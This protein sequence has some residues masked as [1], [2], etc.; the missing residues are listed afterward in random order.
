LLLV[1]R[2][3]CGCS[4]NLFEG[5]TVGTMTPR[6]LE[7]YKFVSLGAFTAQGVKSEP[8]A[9]NG[10]PDE[11]GFRWPARIMSR[12]GWR[13]WIFIQHAFYAGRRLPRIGDGK[14]YN[15]C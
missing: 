4:I 7:D 1:Y 11:P 8:A 9:P 12:R 10:R 15:F 2:L 6:C 3:N 13:R 5:W 14:A